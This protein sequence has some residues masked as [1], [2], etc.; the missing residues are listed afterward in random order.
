MYINSQTQLD[1][2]LITYNSALSALSCHNT[3][4]DRD[5]MHAS[6]CILDLFLQ[7]LDCLCMSGNVDKAIQKISELFTA[8]T[9]SDEAPV[10]LSNIHSCLKISDKCIFWISCVYLVIYR[11]LPDAIAQQFECEKQLSEIEW[12]SIRLLYEEKQRA[13]K[14]ME[15]GV[16]S[17]DSLMKTELLK[18]DINLRSAHFFAVNHIKCM[19]ALDSLEC[20]RHLLD[21][22][23]GLYPSCLEFVLISIRA[24]KQDFGDLRFSGFEEI[25]RNWPKEV[26][27]IQCIWNQ[28]AQCAVQ[29][30]GY[31]CGKELMDRWF[32]SVRE[33]YNLQNGILP[34]MDSESIELASDSI[35]ETLSSLNPIDVMFGFLNL[36]F[37]KLLQN[38]RLGAHVAVEKA[39]KAAIPEYFK[40]CIGEHA[41]F[42]LT[43]DSQLKENASVSGMMNILERYIGNSLAF[44]VPEPLP[45]K[46]INHIKKPKVRQL[47][48][49]IFCPVSRDFSLLNLVLEVWYG[50]TLVP[51]LLKEPKH[52]V[53][54]VEG[55]LDLCPSNY[56]LAMSVCKLLSSQNNSTDVTPTSLLF[57]ASSNLVSAILHAVPI[58]PEHVWAEAAGILCNI[59]GVEVISQ[60][61]YRRAL[62][63]Y[64]F[65]VKL[66]KSYQILHANIGF[67]K[68]IVEEAKAKG[69]DLGN[70]G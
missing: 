2:R 9:N 32:H 50:P 46:F 47:S 14:L 44:S 5:G 29:N 23:L 37:Y 3:D 36:S 45:R 55:I 54:F 66:W 22:Y 51:E 58:P 24:R 67:E 30:G 49:N 52:L 25:L 26:P 38:D 7:M 53:D 43:G 13:V 1:D 34:G 59:R 10:L 16:Y 20:C 40:Y 65:S 56:A 64:P 69:I 11:K 28:Y 63:V 70:L 19:A 4:S 17:I 48:S 31:E 8:D 12:P 57:W 42:F 35:L 15:K 33:V 18:S 6:A 27:G 62:S 39:L 61:F 68:S 21:K 41:M 60:R